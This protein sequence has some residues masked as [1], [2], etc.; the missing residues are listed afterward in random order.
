MKKSLQIMIFI[1]CLF[2]I[3]I[4]TEAQ[5]QELAKFNSSY[6][7]DLEGVNDTFN[8][9]KTYESMGGT[10][11]IYEDEYMGNMFLTNYNDSYLGHIYSIFGVYE[12]EFTNQEPTN[13]IRYDEYGFPTENGIHPNTYTQDELDEK[14]ILNSNN[15][16]Y[17]EDQKLI[18]NYSKI[19]LNLGLV[20]NQSFLDINNLSENEFFSF[21][22]E[23]A[24]ILETNLNNDGFDVSVVYSEPYKTEYNSTNEYN[25]KEFLEQM[26]KKSLEVEDIQMYM[27]E[28][29][30]DTTAFFLSNND[31]KETSDSKYNYD[32][33]ELDNKADRYPNT[34]NATTHEIDTFDALDS[35]FLKAANT[36]GFANSLDPSIVAHEY[37]HTLGLNHLGNT[38]ASTSIDK[39]AAHSIVSP[40]SGGEA[41]GDIM[42][43]SGNRILY[44]SNKNLTSLGYLNYKMG[45]EYYMDSYGYLNKDIP[46]YENKIQKNA[47]FGETYNEYPQIDLINKS[48]GSKLVEYAYYANAI[49]DYTN[50]D[51]YSDLK[52][53]DPLGGNITVEVEDTSNYKM[54]DPYNPQGTKVDLKISNDAGNSKYLTRYIKVQTGYEPYDIV[55]DIMGEDINNRHYTN[56]DINIKETNRNPIEINLKFGDAFEYLN[57]NCTVNGE[58][59]DIENIILNPGDNLNLLFSYSLDNK[60]SGVPITMN[61]FYEGYYSTESIYYV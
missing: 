6:T 36:S 39:T 45:N 5:A 58:A 8:Y 61:T 44:H 32:V 47:S 55:Y 12:V 41:I 11:D 53:V 42:T 38:L 13:V 20:Y 17:I 22:L 16:K 27:D 7:F 14:K 28:S 24:A 26:D 57:I 59:V 30:S 35:Y 37:G 52:F 60:P 18:N 15:K 2:L 56:V 29:N 51:G 34:L 54:G 19:E 3:K 4:N 9:K 46:D 1:F 33:E 31:I 50:E 49:V 43:Y 48:E 21:C 10:V 40:N 23:A 25:Y